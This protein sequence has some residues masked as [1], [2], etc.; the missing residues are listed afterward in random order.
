MIGEQENGDE[1]P[2]RSWN[3]STK[4]TQPRRV[5]GAARQ[6]QSTD[7]QCQTEQGRGEVQTRIPQPTRRNSQHSEER[8]DANETEQQTL[9]R[10][11]LERA[12]ST[13]FGG[14]LQAST[15]DATAFPDVHESE[16]SELSSVRGKENAPPEDSPATKVGTKMGDVLKESSSLSATYRQ[17]RR[18]HAEVLQQA[19]M[20]TKATRE[21][22]RRMKH[23]A[24]EHRERKMTVQALQARIHREI[25]FLS[26]TAAD[27]EKRVRFLA[28]SGE[29][30]NLKACGLIV[31]CLRDAV[32]SFFWTKRSRATSAR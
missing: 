3:S 24:F 15:L 32:R 19:T 28:K 14:L 31:F 20:D 1:R 18:E 9:T 27:L 30:N 12:V 4:L 11:L 23:A 17:R 6:V 29:R 26:A 22:Q 10:E 16:S 5:T 2:K 13:A 25:Q 7:R 21:F 8:A